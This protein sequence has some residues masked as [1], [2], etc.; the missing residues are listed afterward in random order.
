MA[1]SA[2]RLQGPSASC[3]EGADSKVQGPSASSVQGAEVQS[4]ASGGE[5]LACGEGP[6]LVKCSAH[7]LLVDKRFAVVK[8][9]G[10]PLKG[11][12][13]QYVCKECNKLDSRIYR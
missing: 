13:E 10:C 9:K 5:V 1:P 6:E 8:Q 12:K 3:D 7:G 2:S 11:S 4:A